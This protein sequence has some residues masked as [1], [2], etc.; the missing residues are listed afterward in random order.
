M[1]QKQINGFTL[2]ELLIAMAL[3]TVVMAVI[4]SAYQVQV[5]GKNTQEALTEMTQTA[6]AAFEIMESE[7]RMAGLDPTEDAN[8]RI[9]VAN[10]AE[11]VF[12]LD[13]R[14][15]G[16]SNRPDGDCCDEN[17]VVRFHL[18]NDGNDDGVNDNI[19]TGVECHLGRETG[20]GLDPAQGCGGRN[21][22]QP[23]ARN[24]DALNFV[25][26]TDDNNGDGAPDVMATPVATQIARDAIRSIEV[27]IVARAG[28][29]SEG[30]RYDFTNN[31]DYFNQQGVRILAA[32]GDQFRRLRLATTI[33]CR[34]LGI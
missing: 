24:V 12:S 5:R 16:A 10:V 22:L 20:G 9:I 32:T 33:L 25:Y 15:D 19:A 8:A 34:N 1:N 26:L 11:L 13:R 28:T 29:A 3:T 6:R 23:L 21:G 7:I 17:E 4:V 27:T 30:F 2:V 31:T 18:T 14:S